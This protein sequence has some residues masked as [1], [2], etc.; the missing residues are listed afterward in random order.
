QKE[1]RSESESIASAKGLFCTWH[2]WRPAYAVCG[3]CH[4]PFCFEDTTEYNGSLYCLEDIDK[5]SAGRVE[6]TGMEYNNISI[7]ASTLM[8][9][10]FLA[11]MYFANAQL[12]YIIGY[13]NSIGFFR[14]IGT[15]TASY[16]LALLGAITTF[17]TLISAILILTQSRKG[18][19]IG[20]AAGFAN[21]ALF[22]YQFLNTSTVYLLAISILSFAS[23]VTLA[24]SR[25]MFEQKEMP[26]LETKQYGVEW[27][28]AG[29]F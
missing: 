26:Y 2:P 8:F 20:L 24:Y 25:S 14:F 9:A 1:T 21:V 7:V 18:Y 29:K 13:A 22:S 5:V 11:F 28:N 10:T 4:R 19:Y 23:L 3:Y 6:E 12:G 27:P 15:I 17:F 16:G